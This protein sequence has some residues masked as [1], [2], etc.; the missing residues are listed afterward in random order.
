MAPQLWAA[1]YAASANAAE[2]DWFAAAASS[3]IKPI[4]PDG[5]VQP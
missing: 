2:L 5:S 4:A 3:E 1:H